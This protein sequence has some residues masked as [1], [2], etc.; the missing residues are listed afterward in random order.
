MADHRTAYRDTRARTIDLVRGLDDATAEAIVPATPDW[1]IKDVVAH[2]VGVNADVLAGNVEGAG[3]DPWTEVQVATRRD[4]SLADLLAEWDELTE[5]FDAIVPHIP[6]GPAGQL[7]FDAVTH[8]HDL[9]GA[10]DRPGE[11]DSGGMDIAFVW[12]VDVVALLRA[13]KG[14]GPLL[15]HTDHGDRPAGEGEPVA[16]VRA[17]RFELFRAMTGRR[18]REQ[19]DAFTWTGD[20]DARA[21]FAF[22]RPRPTPLVE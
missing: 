13:S 16:S 3:T 7:V 20:P 6:D 1:R 22:F 15:L 8:E 19:I 12:A 17:D 14:V 10:L 21:P 9:R 5:P 11:R 18:S 4:R 2:L